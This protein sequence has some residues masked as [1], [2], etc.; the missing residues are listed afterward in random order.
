M[1]DS[2]K[3]LVFEDAGKVRMDT[4]PIPT[5]SDEGIV[6]KVAY[7][8][9]CGSDVHAYTKGGRFGGL[10]EG[11][12][13]GHEFVGAVVEVG[14]KC[15]DFKVGDR[16]WIDP[17]SSRENPLFCCMAGG[18][19][20][21][22]VSLRAVANETVFKLPDA[23]SF[24]AASLIEPFA[25]GVHTKNRAHVQASD[26]VLMWGAGP[27]GLMG[28]AAMKHQGVKN[29]IVA[30]QMPERIEFARSLGADVFDNTE[31][32]VMDYAGEVFGMI[33]IN[34]Y[35]RPNIDK[36]IDYVGLGILIKEYLERG[37]ANSIFS[38]LGLDARP[39]EIAP[40]EFMS[41]Q[42]TVTGSRAYGP[43]DIPE[44]IETLM[45]KKI[46]IAQIITSVFS[47]DDF[48]KAFETACDKNSGLKVIFEIGGE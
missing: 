42:L 35:V 44:V 31:A 5:A 48:Q 12:Q 13:F 32:D 36:Y 45:D 27:I 2:M 17:A 6:I 23:L 46:D 16:V 19:A 30:E 9:I 25:V 43:E 11:Q 24:K 3:A 33:D 18:F 15:K 38:T 20:E 4:L 21:Y 40:N 14:K 26:N 37:R 29:I 28:W 22:A 34:S 10:G 39:L 1:S 41:K 8:G 7:A 47:L